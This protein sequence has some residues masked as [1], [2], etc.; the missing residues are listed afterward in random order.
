MSGC[1]INIFSAMQHG[2]VE[3]TEKI[4]QFP[5]AVDLLKHRFETTEQRLIAP[6]ITT[7]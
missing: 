3:S 1:R 7:R 5:N 4:S 6:Q 2:S